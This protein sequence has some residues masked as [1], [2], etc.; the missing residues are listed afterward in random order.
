MCEEIRVCR[1]AST[2]VLE[3]VHF[4]TMNLIVNVSQCEMREEKRVKKFKK[5]D[6]FP[7]VG[8][9]VHRFSYSHF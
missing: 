7:L 4:Y 9:N 5:V 6:S 2:R 3:P 1:V 8:K